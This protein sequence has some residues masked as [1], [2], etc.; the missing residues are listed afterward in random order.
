M[1]RNRTATCIADEEKSHIIYN[2]YI[3]FANFYEIFC[4]ATNIIDKKETRAIYNFYIVFA[5]FYFIISYEI[6]TI[7]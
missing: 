7:D 5:I 6:F 3:V 1:G 2:S 4:T